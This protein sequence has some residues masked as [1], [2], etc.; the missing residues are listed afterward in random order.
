MCRLFLS[1]RNNDTKQKMYEFLKQSDHP[2]KNTPGINNHRDLHIQK[3]GFGFAWFDHGWKIYK[4]PFIYHKDNELESKINRMK[5]EIVIGQ[6]RNNDYARLPK[7]HNNTHPFIYENHVFVQNGHIKHFKKYRDYLV[8][9]IASDLLM[10]IMGETDTEFLFFM[11]LTILKSKK[12]INMNTIEKS[13]LEL[14]NIFR[15]ENIDLLAN[16]IYANES[17]VLVTRYIHYDRSH[18]KR[19]QYPLSLYYSIENDKLLVSSEPVS[20]KYETFPMNTM[21]IIDWHS[22]KK[23][24]SVIPLMNN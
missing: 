2:R 14:F 16:I 3:D 8:K 18:Y 20:E 17:F 15:E 22:M 11:F 1:I 7:H 6:I 23:I 5:K 4:N 21:M 12:T 10:H 19:E 13:I 9:Y 24:H